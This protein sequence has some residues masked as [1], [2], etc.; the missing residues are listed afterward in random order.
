MYWHLLLLLLILKCGLLTEADR[1]ADELDKMSLR[2]M[3]QVN[4]VLME[5]TSIVLLE[6]VLL[7]FSTSTTDGGALTKCKACKNECI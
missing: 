7:T 5:H 1:S 6:E 2:L 3:W 4:K